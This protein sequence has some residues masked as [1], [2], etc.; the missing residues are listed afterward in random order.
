MHKQLSIVEIVGQILFGR[1]GG[2]KA[3]RKSMYE[4][5]FTYLLQLNGVLCVLK[6]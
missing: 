2:V 5:Q 6:K 1:F 3:C 4:I